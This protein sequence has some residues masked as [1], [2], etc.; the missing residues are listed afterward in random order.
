MQATWECY[1]ELARRYERL[2]LTETPLAQVYSEASL[3][4]AYLKA[5]KIKPWREVQPNVPPQ[6]LATIM[7]SYYGG[8]SE[9]RIRRELRQ[10]VLCDFL[11]MYPTVCTL[12]GL[13]RFV[14]AEGMT[15]H[16]ATDEVRSFL[17]EVSIADQQRRETWPQMTALVR[18]V[19]RGD[20]FPVRAKYGDEA[21]ATIGLNY[22][23]SEQPLWFTLADCVA[24]K[25]LTGRTPHIIEALTFEP[26]PVQSGLRPVAIA[27][28]YDYRVDPV[29][30]DFYKRLI[31]LRQ[32]VKLKRD[33]ATAA[34][35]GE[36]D[37][38]QNALKIAANATSY[39][40]FVEM[41]VKEL[42]ESTPLAVHSAT[43]ESYETAAAKVEEPGRSFHPLLATLITGAARLML[44]ITERLVTDYAL[45]WTFC[46]TDSMA[47]AKPPA[48]AEPIFHQRVNNVVNWFGQ[49][50]PYNF[51]GSILKVEGV[52]AA[53]NDAGGP[54]PLFCWAVSAKRYA[55][56]NVDRKGRPILRKASAHGLGHLRSPYED[57]SPAVGIPAPRVPL[58]EI[59]VEL[60]QHDLWIKIVRAALSGDPDRVDLSFHPALGKPAISR[61]AATTPKLLRWF[62]QFNANQPY[63]RQVKPFGFLLSLFAGGLFADGGPTETLAADE[64]RPRRR[65]MHLVRPVAPFD[66]NPAEAVHAAFDR[67]SGDPVPASALKTYRQVLAQYHLHP[68]TKFANGDFVDRGTTRRRH[69]RVSGIRNIGKEA[70]HWEEQFYLGLNE[71]AEV[72][73]GLAPSGQEQKLSELRAL[74]RQIGQRKL[75]ERLRI[76]RTTLSKIIKHEILNWPA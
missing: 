5:M 35:K 10:V 4:K 45:Q 30:D 6:L 54:E 65:S 36:F 42:G 7:G 1:A 14:I 56:F 76:S 22:L 53:T 25:L 9:V 39:G 57:T 75:A 48:M 27:G 71:E 23:T 41:N 32:S 3:G 72:D 43:G 59:G 55:L 18:V 44:A 33:R 11:S 62:R 68:E 31:E 69:V 63:D 8:R 70:D 26:G 58:H 60:W 38:E 29:Q 64:K 61:Y 66:S 49:L 2:G 67:D 24:S 13:W 28:N 74:A 21:Q 46:D 51:E 50:N 40:I 47:I 17:N 16:D 37:T 52:N 15:W 19:P 12:M 73:H 20:I 34:E